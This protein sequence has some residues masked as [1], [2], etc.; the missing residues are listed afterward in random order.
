[1]FVSVLTYKKSPADHPGALLRHRNWADELVRREKVIL[2][3]PQ[4]SGEG[5]VMVFAVKTRD[6]LDILMAEDPFLT[7]GI[8]EYEVI[9]FKARAYDP[10]LWFV[11]Q[12]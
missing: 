8:A 9:E 10:R 2:S 7:E 12:L 5:G 3:G 11:A 4:A 1:M 6:E